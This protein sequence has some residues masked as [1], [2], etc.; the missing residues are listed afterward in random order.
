MTTAE[1]VKGIIG[2]IGWV[3][4]GQLGGFCTCYFCW[5]FWGRVTRGDI[6][7]GVV[8][9]AIAGPLFT[10]FAGI[11]ALLTFIMRLIKSDRVV[12]RREDN[13]DGR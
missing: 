10:V 6:M 13:P 1:I 8:L 2:I 9:G 4:F 12:W 3:A 11:V 7:F 5:V